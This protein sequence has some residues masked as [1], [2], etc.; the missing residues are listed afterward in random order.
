MSAAIQLHGVVLQQGDRTL[1]RDLSLTLQPGERWLVLGENGCGKSTLLS[2]L[3]GW[4]PPSAGAVTLGGTDIARLPSGQRATQL[5]WLS[6]QD[7]HPFPMTVMEKSLTGRH[8][9]IPRW[10]W[11]SDTDRRIALDMLAR[12]DIAHL[13]AHDLATLSGGE[14][15]RASL[16]AVMAQQT[17]WLLL[18]EP[19]SQLDIRH[20]QAGLQQLQQLAEAGKGMVV[21]SHDPNHAWAFASHVLMLFGDGRWQAGTVAA[22]LTADNLSQLYHCPVEALDR[23]GMPWF[24]PCR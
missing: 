10:S 23:H 4:M 15:R 17:D 18:D 6:Q 24:L 5:A 14:R 9:Y 11:E 12:L 20:Q 2:V 21:V 16:A 19:L 7:E 1:C 13:A 8:P 3:A 22:Q